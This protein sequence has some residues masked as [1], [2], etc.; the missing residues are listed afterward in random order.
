MSKKA[1]FAIAVAALGYFVDVYDLVLFNVVRVASLKALALSPSEIT[2]IGLA[3]LNIQLI[4]ML[5][6]GLLWG[7]LG[8]KKGRVSVLFGSIL[9]YSLANIMNAFVSDVTSYGICRFF[10]GVG[11]AG[12]FGVGITLVNELLPTQKRGYG[13]LVI[14]FSGILGAIT[15]GIIGDLLSWQQTYISGGI[16]GLGLLA[17]RIRLSES[18]FFDKI[19]MNSIQRGSLLELIRSRPLLCKYLRCIFVGSPIWIIIGLFVSLAPE[20]AR[21]LLIQGTVSTGRA[22]LFFNIGFGTGEIFSSLASQSLK[23]RKKAIFLFLCSTS[24]FSFLLLALRGSSATEFYSICLLLGISTGY[25]A[26]FMVQTTEQFGTNLRATA[27]TSAP[28]VVRALVVPASM[29]L[30]LIRGKLGFISSL[31]LIEFTFLGLAFFSLFTLE[32]TFSRNL[33]F[34]E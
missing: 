29:I 19:K 32:E 12:E 8:D 31:A 30:E 2:S 5:L 14:A 21:E 26:I 4:G 1:W 13:T 33:D 28:N 27:T 3:L 22:L 10:A 9:L 17:M 6:G 20:L 23:S 7:V 11:L 34:V 25:W 16:L 18:E 15:G 24:L